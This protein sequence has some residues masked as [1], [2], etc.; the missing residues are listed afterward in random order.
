MVT[1]KQAETLAIRYSA[2]MAAPV[3]SNE[4]WLW[5]NLLLQIQNETK[6]TLAPT[7]FLNRIINRPIDKVA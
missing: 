7:D 4:C 1:K 2:F 3:E 6:I 5:A